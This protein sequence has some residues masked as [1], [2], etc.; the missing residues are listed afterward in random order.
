VRSVTVGG[1]VRFSPLWPPEAI[2][3]LRDLEANNDRDWFRRA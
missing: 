2:E 3:F 1:D